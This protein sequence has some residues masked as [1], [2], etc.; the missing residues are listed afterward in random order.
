MAAG[1]NKHDWQHTS[2]LMAWTQNAGFGAKEA[3]QPADLLPA[4]L[5]P[6]A[7]APTPKP[8]KVAI[9]ALDIFL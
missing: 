3:V 4:D 2:H 6:T 8:I 7:D 5:K 9:D 1:K